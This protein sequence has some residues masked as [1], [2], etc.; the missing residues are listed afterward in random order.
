MSV[1]ISNISGANKKYY[2]AQEIC[3]YSTVKK[4]TA[5]EDERLAMIFFFKY[6]FVKIF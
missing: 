5:A 4:D 2:F 3:L 6:I 1:F